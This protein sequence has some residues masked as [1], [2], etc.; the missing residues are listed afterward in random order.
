MFTAGF[1]PD[2]L[3]GLGPMYRYFLSLITSSSLRV[4]RPGRSLHRF[5]GEMERAV[6]RVTGERALR[7]VS[8]NILADVYAQTELSKTVLYPYCA[9][10]ALQIDYRQSLIKKEL[11]GYNADIIC[12]Q[13]VDKAVFA[14]SL[15]PALDAFGL[16]GVFR[17]KERQHE[18]LATFFRTSKLELIGRYDVTLSDALTSESRHAELWR[19]MSANEALRDKVTQRST[20]L[21]VTVLQSVKDPSRKLCVANTHLYWHPKGSHVRLIQMAVA[22]QHLQWVTSE[23]HPGTPLLLSGDLNSPPSSG[24]FQLITRGHIPEDHSDWASEGPDELCPLEVTSPFQLASA[25]GEPA[26]TNYVGGFHGCLDYILVEPSALQV[27]QVI[28]MPSHQD[29]TTYQAL[30]S[31]SHPSDHIALVCD[32]VW[33]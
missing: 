15:C 12:L 31:V 7:V 21:Q 23:V 32:L 16:N 6:V 4:L 29:I 13:E 14:D 22:L 27:E 2:R 17:M 25:C 33:Q 1:R 30:P 19:K 5:H 20:A 11:S 10:Y 3:H 8:Y 28:P 26:Y 18:G 9:P 24:V